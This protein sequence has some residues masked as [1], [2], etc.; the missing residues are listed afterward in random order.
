MKRLATTRE[1]K[2]SITELRDPVT[3]ELC[4]DQGS[5]SQIATNFYSRLFNPDTIDV[6]AACALLRSVPRHLKLSSG[7]QDKLME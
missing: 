1:N 6:G 4:S 3:E 7:Q 5:I 2:C